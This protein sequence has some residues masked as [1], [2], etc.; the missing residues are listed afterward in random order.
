MMAD[1]RNGG[2]LRS[3]RSQRATVFPD[4]PSNAARWAWDRPA[5]SRRSRRFTLEAL[6]HPPAGIGLSSDVRFFVVGDVCIVVH[7]EATISIGEDVGLVQEAP[8]GQPTNIV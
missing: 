3:P 8:I 7:R 2:G 4:T 5:F 1:S 6:R